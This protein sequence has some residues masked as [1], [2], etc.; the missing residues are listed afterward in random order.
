[1]QE[2]R[3]WLESAESAANSRDYDDPYPNEFMQTAALMA[4][5][6]ALVGQV[7]DSTRTIST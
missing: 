7:S 4:I 3:E 1:M 5:A 6:H 2:A